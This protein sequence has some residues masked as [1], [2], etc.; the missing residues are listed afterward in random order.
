LGR[1][2]HLEP[3]HCQAEDDGGGPFHGFNLWHLSDFAQS[4]VCDS[5]VI[6]WPACPPL[7]VS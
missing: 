3:D 2:H 4:R 6:S 5:R 7:P 1:R